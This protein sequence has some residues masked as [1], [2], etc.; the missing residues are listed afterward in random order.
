MIQVEY[1]FTDHEMNKDLWYSKKALFEA[2]FK[3]FYLF[4]KSKKEGRKDLKKHSIKNL[5]D[6]YAFADWNAGGMENCYA[7]GFAFYPYFLTVVD[8]DPKTTAR[9]KLKAQPCDTFLGYCVKNG[10]FLDFIDFLLSYF[11]YWRNDETCTSFDPYNHADQFFNSSWAVLVDTCK[12]F[13][14]D[15]E[16]IFK[17]MPFRIKY[18]IDNI[19]GTFKTPF[20]EKVT[21]KKETTL[22]RVRV[23][24]YE[25]KGWFDEKGN[26]VIKVNKDMT[27]YG[28]L[29]RK[30]FYDYWEKEEPKIIKVDNPNWKKVDPA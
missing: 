6:F 10:K 24:G 8:E 27:V 2:F 11:P 5:K 17:W 15:S 3:E 29:E 12:L 20:K 26:E 4:I 23:S 18:V 25:F 30:D 14:F 16:T 7:M 22:K 9:E 28:K 19:P 21:Y 13:Y 1:K